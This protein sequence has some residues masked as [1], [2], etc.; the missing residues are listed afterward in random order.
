M[1]NDDDGVLEVSGL[2]SRRVGELALEH[3]IVIHELVHQRESLEDAY[4]RLTESSVDFHGADS[5]LAGGVR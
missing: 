1:V 4:F 5:V 3:R 2:D